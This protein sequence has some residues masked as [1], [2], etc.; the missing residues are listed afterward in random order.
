MAT[1]NSKAQANMQE[2]T[3]GGTKW[4]NLSVEEV[5]ALQGVTAD[6]LSDA[7]AAS[8]LQ[9]FGS[10]ELTPPPKPGFLMKLFLQ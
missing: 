2:E 8:R 7:E 3:F 9:K 5:M 4:H 6:G 10:N 1:G